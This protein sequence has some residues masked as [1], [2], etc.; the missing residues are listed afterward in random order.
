[1]KKQPFLGFGI[2]LH[3]ACSSIPCA[4]FRFA[5]IEISDSTPFCLQIM[6]REISSAGLLSK[7]NRNLAHRI[8]EHTVLF[9]SYIVFINREQ[10]SSSEVITFLESDE[11]SS[12]AVWVEDF[13]SPFGVKVAMRS[14]FCLPKFWPESQIETCIRTNCSNSYTLG[15]N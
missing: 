7:N 2:Y 13:K 14:N 11:T 4:K 10:G 12:Y 9:M 1:M 5:L 15:S 8:G 3:T 6:S